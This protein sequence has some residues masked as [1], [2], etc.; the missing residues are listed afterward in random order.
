MIHDPAR[1][2][3]VNSNHQTDPELDQELA[4]TFDLEL[5]VYFLF[6]RAQVHFV[7]KTLEDL[8]QS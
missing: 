7:A 4:Q 5:C 8:L 3:Q 2:C 1:T 6:D